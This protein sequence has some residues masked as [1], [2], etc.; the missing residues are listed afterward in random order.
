MPLE[1]TAPIPGA[2]TIPK[3]RQDLGSKDVFLKML[4]AQMQ[5]QD[6]LNPADSTQMSA[7]LAQFNMVEQQIDTNKY[8]QQIAANQSEPGNNLDMASAGYLGHTVMVNQSDIQYSGSPVD[9]QVTL[10][11]N[12]ENIYV[13]ISDNTGAPV[14]TMSLAAMPA[15]Q[16]S[17]SWDGRNDQGIKVDTGHYSISIQAFDA[18]G[19]AVRATPQYAGVVDAVRTTPSGIELVVGGIATSLANIT[20]VRL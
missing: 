10:E 7:Q 17:L 3:P 12:A 20:E 16:A 15:G 4:V 19:Q 8:L 6:P 14:R 18:T 2:Q 1:V 9:F 11:Q 13:T 5:N